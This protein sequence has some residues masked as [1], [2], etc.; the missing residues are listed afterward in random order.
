MP[1][2][3]LF[4]T[5]MDRAV[6]E[7]DAVDHNSTPIENSYA[8]LRHWH[9]NRQCCYGLLLDEMQQAEASAEC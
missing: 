6:Y 2:I 3:E 5:A 8:A 1:D 4:G 7:W 9:S